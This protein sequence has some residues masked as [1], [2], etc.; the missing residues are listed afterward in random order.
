M[1]LDELNALPHEDAVDALYSCC[2]SSRWVDS[3]IARR[4]FQTDDELFSVADEAWREL[5]P[6]DWREAFS[7]HPRIGAEVSGKE[8]AEQAG[9]QSAES[10]IRQDLARANDKYEERFGHTYIVCASG[11]SAEEMLAIANERLDNDPHIE[12]R[13]AAEEQQKIMQLRLRKLVS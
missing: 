10:S 2:G 9:A 13:I 5:G 1:T 6:T 8:A 12:L 7:H 3:I 4:P 11:K